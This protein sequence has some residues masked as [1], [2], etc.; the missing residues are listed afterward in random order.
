MET[1]DWR[2]AGQL[3]SPTVHIEFSETG[4][5]FDGAN[6]L[7]MNQAY[8]DG[9]SIEVIETLANKDRV[10]AQVRVVQGERTFWCAGFY[11]VSDGVI[12]SGTEHWVDEDSGL[13]P[14]WRKQFVSE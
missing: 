10:A 4:E 3:L 2:G 13:A 5:R 8:P 1:R 6:F 11:R 14:E 12:T 9:W 7:A